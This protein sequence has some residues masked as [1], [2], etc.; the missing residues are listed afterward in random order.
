MKKFEDVI[1][2][3]KNLPSTQ[4]TLFGQIFELIEF[5]QSVFPWYRAIDLK[6]IK[7]SLFL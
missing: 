7:R 1:D 5:Q 6:A 2:E 3:M 4:R